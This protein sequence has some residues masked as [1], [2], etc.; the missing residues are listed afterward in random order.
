ME[1]ET[2]LAYFCSKMEVFLPVFPFLCY[3]L[4]GGIA[5]PNASCPILVHTGCLLRSILLNNGD[6]QPSSM[7][8]NWTRGSVV[9]CLFYRPRNYQN[10]AHGIQNLHPYDN[11]SKNK[12]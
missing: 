1:R 4:G 3:Q 2:T 6:Q 9:Y 11:A 12:P 7:H 5:P 8:Q 10:S